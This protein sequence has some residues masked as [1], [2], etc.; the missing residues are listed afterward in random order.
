MRYLFVGEKKS[1]TAR[2]RGWSW[3]DGRLAAKQLF[4]AF[5]TLS[6]KPE[7]QIFVNIS[8]PRCRLMCVLALGAQRPVV[9]MGQIASD[10]LTKYKIEHIQIVHPAARGKIRAKALYAA[11]LKERLGL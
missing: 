5:A 1:E 10:Y 3:K 2:K 7:D 6:I 8:Q 9:A 11:H 4:D